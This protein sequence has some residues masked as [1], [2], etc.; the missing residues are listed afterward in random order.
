[1]REE[2]KNPKKTSF[3]SKD[4]EHQDPDNRSFHSPN[5][6]RNMAFGC[7]HGRLRNYAIDYGILRNYAVDYGTLRNYAVDYETLR[8]RAVNYGILRITA[9]NPEEDYE[10]THLTAD[11]CG[12][13]RSSMFDSRNPNNDSSTVKNTETREP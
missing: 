4:S 2:K 5:L 3:P 1:M 9:D 7:V 6:A 11:D 12:I 8:N 10:T 13:L